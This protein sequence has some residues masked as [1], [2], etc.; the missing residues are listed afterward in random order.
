LRTIWGVSVDRVAA[1]FGIDF[2]NY[3][4]KEADK[5]ILQGLLALRNNILTTTREGKFLA[6][7]LASDLFFVDLE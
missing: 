7:G 2:K 5:Y 4:I 1:E 6:D 3:L